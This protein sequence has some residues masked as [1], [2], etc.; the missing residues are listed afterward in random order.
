VA[1]EEPDADYGFGE[2][3][4]AAFEDLALRPAGR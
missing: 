1:A 4:I 2:A 3:Q